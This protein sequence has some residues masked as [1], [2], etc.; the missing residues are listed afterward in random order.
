[1]CHIRQLITP[2]I[3][4]M[5]NQVDLLTCANHANAEAITGML[6]RRREDA[7]RRFVCSNLWQRY[8]VGGQPGSRAIGSLSAADM[9]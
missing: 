8:C 5:Y 6:T 9:R 3:L 7:V 4:D 1:M 2:V